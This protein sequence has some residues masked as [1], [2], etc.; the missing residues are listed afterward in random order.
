M[1]GTRYDLVYFIDY[2]PQ[3]LRKTGS[4]VFLL[5]YVYSHAF[6]CIL[7]AIYYRLS[8]MSLEYWERAQMS[9]WRTKGRPCKA[10]AI[11]QPFIFLCKCY[12]IF[13][14]A[15]WKLLLA[16]LF[17]SIGKRSLSL[18][19]FPSLLKYVDSENVGQDHNVP[20][21]QWRHSP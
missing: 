1:L 13:H 2:L 3:L 10:M 17:D 7:A 15:V 16:K 6:W 21:S 9:K 18:A 8:K 4:M 14:S 12:S 19:P 5:K 11:S 20:H